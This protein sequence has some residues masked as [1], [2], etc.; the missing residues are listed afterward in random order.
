MKKIIHLAWIIFL[1]SACALTERFFAQNSPASSSTHESTDSQLEALIDAEEQNSIFNLGAD[2]SVTPL[3]QNQDTLTSFQQEQDDLLPTISPVEEKHDVLYYQ[4][5]QHD[6][7]M[8]IAFKIYGDYHR[9]KELQQLNPEFANKELTVGAQIKYNR[10]LQEFQY[11]PQGLPY[12]IKRNDTLGSISG[13]VYGITTRWR[14]IYN[15]NRILIRDPN[16]IF[17]GFTLYYVPD[18]TLASDQF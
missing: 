14:E 8:L 16:L 17:A 1:F 6:T 5:K 3:P 9:W 12:L 2:E 11:N 18:Q 7:L 10:P 15:N 13:D 4:I